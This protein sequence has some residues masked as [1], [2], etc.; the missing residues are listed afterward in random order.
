DLTLRLKLKSNGSIER[1]KTHLVEKG[2]TQQ[3]VVD[4]F[5]TFSPIVKITTIWLNW[6]LQQLDVHNF[7]LHGELNE[8]VCMVIPQ[9]FQTSKLNQVCKPFKSLHGL[10]K[11]QSTT[12]RITILLVYI[13]DIMSIEDDLKEILFVKV[14]LDQKFK[15]KDLVKLQFFLD[16]RLPDLT[17]K[18]ALELLDDVGLLACQL[19]STPMGLN[20]KLSTK[21]G[22]SHMDHSSYCRLIDKLIYL[23]NITRIDIF[24]L[25]PSILKHTTSS[26]LDYDSCPN[27][28]K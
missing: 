12:S 1:Y 26:D 5:E 11:N 7:F 15:I 28:Q 23:T 10:K 6:H 3:E 14:Y 22:P 18:Y 20:L 25:I 17:K 24:F 13:K 9:G 19:A 4:Y 2:Y 27:S 16:R 8:E 21:D